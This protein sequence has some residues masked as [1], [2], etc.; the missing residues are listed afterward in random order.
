MSE[1]WK[2]VA[3]TPEEYPL[4]R[5]G[6]AERDS[7]TRKRSLLRALS[8]RNIGVIYVWI[9][10]IVVFSLWSPLFATQETAIFTLNQAAVAGL[11]S[12]AIIVPLAAGELDISV[13]YTFSLAGVLVAYLL[14]NTTMGPLEAVLLT[15]A[16]SLFIGLVNAFTVVVLRVRSLIGTMG[17][18]GIITAVYIALSGNQVITGGRVEGDFTKLATT[19]IWGDIQLPVLYLLVAMI[20]LGILLERTQFGRQ[21]YAVGFAPET[22]RLTGVPVKL[23]AVV[24]FVI[25]SLLAGFAG[26]VLAAGSAAGSPDVGLHYLVP[27]FATAF[28]GAT[29]FRRGWF[30]PWGTVASVLMLSTGQQGLF[31][32]SGQQ[33]TTPLFNGV[34]L[35]AAVALVGFERGELRNALARNVGFV[36]APKSVDTPTK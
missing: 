8:P 33:W 26:L 36:R 32:V 28:L 6:S 2:T 20:G 4:A 27:A 34:V 22:A 21:A 30:N 7:D 14:Q 9:L 24:V 10:V 3:V 29:Q 25:A 31:L 15:L 35:I 18:G 5:P 1:S 12:L 16:A 13:A 17:M 23:V 11:I 19:Q